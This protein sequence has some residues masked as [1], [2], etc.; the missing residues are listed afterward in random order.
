ME[1]KN[2]VLHLYL[3]FWT[4]ILQKNSLVLLLF[5][6]SV[7]NVFPLGMIILFGGVDIVDID[8]Y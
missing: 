3:R 1:K 8:Y 6:T 7:M 2:S 5:S 4:L